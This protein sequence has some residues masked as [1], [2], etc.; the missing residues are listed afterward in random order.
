MAPIDETLSADQ[1]GALAWLEQVAR[2]LN[3]TDAPEQALVDQVKALIGTP[4]GRSLLDLANATALATAHNH[5]GTY[6]RATS[7]W[8]VGFKPG[9]Y[10]AP[11]GARSAFAM[12]LNA[13][14]LIPFRVPTTTT[15]DRIGILVTTLAASSAVR[16]GIYES[17][18]DGMPGDLVLDAGTVDS[19]TTGAKEIALSQVLTPNLYWLAFVAQGGNPDCRGFSTTTDQA[20]S[21]TSLAAVLTSPPPT[22]LLQAG[23]A[24]ALPAAA[25]TDLSTSAGSPVIAVRAA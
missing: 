13:L 8:V 16:L 10:Y 2:W 6:A 25:A 5:D 24:G 3:G 15:F 14:H 18:A 1:T 21:T 23:V 11:G 7:T 20:V 17:L 22:G 9:R 12:G 19:T 4:F